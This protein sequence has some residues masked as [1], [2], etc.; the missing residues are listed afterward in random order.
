MDIVATVQDELAIQV[1]NGEIM[2][3][4]NSDCESSSD[5]NPVSSDSLEMDLRPSSPFW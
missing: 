2:E 4:K 1:D 3:T 5:C